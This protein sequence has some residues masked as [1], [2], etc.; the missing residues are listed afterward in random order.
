[1]LK[2][3]T[4][5]LVFAI[6]SFL[7]YFYFFLRKKLEINNVKYFIVFLFCMFIFDVYGML[8]LKYG[9]NNAFYNLLSLLEF[10]L[11]FLFYKKNSENNLTKLSINRLTILY[12]LI[13][14]LSSLYYGIDVLSIRY[15]T[16]APVFGAAFIGVVLMLYL[17]EFLLSE[18]VL[19]YKRN[20]CFWITTGL[21]LYYLGTMP[22][23]ALFNFMKPGSSF[24]SLYNILY[25][26]TIAM[27]SCFLIGLIWSWKRVK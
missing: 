22:L 10:N 16:I 25:I 23:T 14:F 27:H 21:L 20:V 3:N 6:I 17:R 15:N 11:L 18:K 1:M 5:A 4:I 24:L 13:Y 8:F 9:Y 12:G 7:L 19:N 2:L 26:L